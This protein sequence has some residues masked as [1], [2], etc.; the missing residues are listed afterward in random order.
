M[1][2]SL[3]VVVSRFTLYSLSV[4]C[5]TSLFAL[6]LPFLLNAP[7]Y[8]HLALTSVLLYVSHHHHLPPI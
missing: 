5:D 3:G 8:L 7:D 2:W 4:F 6:F 1:I